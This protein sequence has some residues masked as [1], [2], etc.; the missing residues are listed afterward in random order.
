LRVG[1]GLLNAP[2]VISV[3]DERYRVW[4][5]LRLPQ[6]GIVFLSG[7]PVCKTVVKAGPDGTIAG[8]DSSSHGSANQATA[9]AIAIGHPSTSNGSDRQEAGKQESGKQESGKQEQSKQE[10]SYQEASKQESSRQ[11]A[12]RQAASSQEASSQEASTK[13]PAQKTA[14]QPVVIPPVP[15]SVPRVP[16][17][18]KMPE[19]LPHGLARN[20]A[21]LTK[22]APPAAPVAA[23]VTAPVAAPPPAPTIQMFQPTSRT[24]SASNGVDLSDWVNT[25]LK[26]G[27]R[28]LLVDLRNVSFMD[29]SG[30]A[31]L[32]T[33]LRLVKQAG[34]R[35]ALCS[36]SGQTRMLLE[37]TNTDQLFE[38][39]TNRQAFESVLKS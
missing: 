20:A 24:F 28:N 27:W 9:S 25:S 22:D 38:V 1:L 37:M 18:P 29:S 15:T 31:A 8:R 32:T 39:Y 26:A 4:V 30:L 2:I 34:G 17:P 14:A 33:A 23:P 35:F 36:L 10:A 5:Q 6:M 19:T 11:A 13:T 16:T 7:S 12:S 21:V 3:S